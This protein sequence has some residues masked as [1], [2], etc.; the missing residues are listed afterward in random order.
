MDQPVGLKRKHPHITRYRWVEQAVV[1]VGELEGRVGFAS[2][3][4]PAGQTI[5]LLELLEVERALSRLEKL[6]RHARNAG[7]KS[8]VNSSLNSS[9]R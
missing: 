6:F 8:A 3:L 2:S 9:G 7:P 4:Y 1:P 5:A